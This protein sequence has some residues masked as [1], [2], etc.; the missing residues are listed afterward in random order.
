MFHRS[1]IFS[2]MSTISHHFSTA[3]WNTLDPRS[4]YHCFFASSADQ[5]VILLWLHAK[6]YI[7]HPDKFPSFIV[8]HNELGHY[9]KSTCVSLCWDLK[10]DHPTTIKALVVRIRRTDKNMSYLCRCRLRFIKPLSNALTQNWTH[11]LLMPR[12]LI[13]CTME[14]LI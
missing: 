3:H 10:R 5:M 6:R 8:Y 1:D 12:L 14:Y 4:N 9:C 2:R 13:E 7:R 11:F